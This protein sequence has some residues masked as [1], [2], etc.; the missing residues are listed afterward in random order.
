MQNESKQNKSAK[1]SY[2]QQLDELNEKCRQCHMK[3]GTPNPDHCDYHCK[4]GFE[5]HKLYCMMGEAPHK[6]W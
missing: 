4:I 5:I 6:N 2:Q 1:S 3:N